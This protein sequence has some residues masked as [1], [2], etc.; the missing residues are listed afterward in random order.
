M[1]SWEEWSGLKI[2]MWNF[3]FFFGTHWPGLKKK[4]PEMGIGTDRQNCRRISRSDATNWEMNFLVETAVQKFWGRRTFSSSQRS[5][6]SRGGGKATLLLFSLPV[7]HLVLDMGIVAEHSEVNTTPCSRQRT[8]KTEPRGT[9][10]YQGDG[11]CEELRK[12]PHRVVWEPLDSPQA[13]HMHFDAKQ[14][15]SHFENLNPEMVHCPDLRL[16]RGLENITNWNHNPQK[17]GWNV[18]S[19][20]N[21]VDWMLRQNCPGQ[22]YSACEEPG[23]LSLH[24]K[25]GSTDAIQ[26][27]RCWNYLRKVLKQ[28]YRNGKGGLF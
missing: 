27:G 20:C 15:T 18:Q 22:S 12:E 23:N 25:R 14:H 13:E 5:F 21:Q 19:G 26:E 1:W 28:Y 10:K 17:A 16:A 4:N 9:G 24:G 6:V 7:Y 8:R 2:K 3:F 11:E